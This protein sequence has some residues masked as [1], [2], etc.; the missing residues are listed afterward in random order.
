MVVKIPFQRPFLTGREGDYVAEVLASGKLS[1]NGPMTQ[2]CHDW[3]ERNVGCAKALLTQ[4]CTSALEMAAIIADIAAGDEVIMPSYT[5]ATSASAFVMRGAIP[6][7]VDIRQDTLN[8]DE[9]LVEAAITSRTRAIVAVHYAGVGCDMAALKDIAERHGLLL[10]EDAAQ[11]I[12]ARYQD[13]PLGSIGHMGAYSFHETKNIVSGEGGA[14]LINDANLIARAEI[15]WEKGTNRSQFIRGQVDK[16]TW[17]DLG[18]SYLPSEITGAVLRAQL[19]GAD[20]ITTERLRLWQRYY[21][22]FE[23][24]EREKRLCRQ[25]VPQDCAHNGHIFYVL[26]NTANE[27]NRV[28]RV[29]NAAGIGATFHYIP[30]HSSPAGQRFGRSSGTMTRTD[31]LAA[32]LLRLPMPPMTDEIQDSVIVHVRDAILS[33]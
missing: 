4:S 22:A 1:G 25:V 21:D 17:I 23:G 14:L 6:V 28:L 31:D 7:F 16:Y 19:E 29:L 20:A 26:L 27:R 10:I 30:L 32:R 24:L 11:G 9:S 33:E 8:L 15:A 5:F 13:K 2:Y 18:S 3:L 12:L